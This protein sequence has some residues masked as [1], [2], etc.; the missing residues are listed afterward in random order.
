MKKA[1]TVLAWAADCL[2]TETL[3]GI[4][5]SQ[6][7]DIEQAWRSA[8]EATKE[9]REIKAFAADP[10]ATFQGWTRFDADHEVVEA[11][12]RAKN[13]GTPVVAAV[14]RTD[15]GE[16][17]LDAQEF[18]MKRWIDSGGNPHV[19]RPNRF[20]VAS[21]SDDGA[22]ARLRSHLQTFDVTSLAE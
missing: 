12:Y 9:R 7:D 15:A 18:S 17:E 2:E 1:K 10:P 21:G 4:E 22:Y 14:F 3:E 5:Q 6:F 8:V 20:C 16:D 13:H 19:A 11:A